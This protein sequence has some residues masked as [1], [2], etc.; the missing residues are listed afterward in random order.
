MTVD[1]G[2]QPIGAVPWGSHFCHFFRDAQDLSE[3][4][5][6]YFKTGLEA[7]QACIWITAAPF[8]KADALAN[9]RPYFGDLETRQAAGQL[10]IFDH[11][12]WYARSKDQSTNEVIRGWIAAKNRALQSGFEG[13]RVSGNSAFIRNEDWDNFNAY[14]AAVREAFTDQQIIALCSYQEARWG[15]DAVL[16]VVNT[17]D[18]ALAR[19]RGAWQLIESASVKKTKQVLA[20]LNSALEQRVEERTRALNDAL[21]HQTTLTAELSHRVKNTIASVQAIVD[22]TLRSAISPA[23]ARA[24]VAGRLTALGRAHDQLAA[25]HWTG[26]NL[27]QVIES[28]IGAFSHRIR[29]ESVDQLL[30]ARAALDLSLVLHELM[31]NASKYGAL[32]NDYGYVSIRAQLSSAGDALQIHWHEHDGPTV[33]EPARKG[34]GTRLLRDLILHDLRGECELRY[35]ADGVTCVMQMPLTEI[36]ARPYLCPVGCSH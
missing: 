12:E 33:S 11:D 26:V 21:A 30:R 36:A 2:L 13:L 32:S 1:T 7:N 3:T 6:P 23:Q 5:V 4:L 8:T 17:H 20:A 9:L 35:A 27:R 16:D 31:T 34:F 18:F 25:G 29:L 14:E 24:T 19:R 15:A 10:A 22:Q 28:A